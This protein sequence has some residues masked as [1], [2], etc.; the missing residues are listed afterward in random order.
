[1]HTSGKAAAADLAPA[2]TAAL[3]ACRTALTDHEAGFSTD[4]ELRANLVERG[5]VRHG[6]EVYLLDLDEGVWHCYDGVTVRGP[7]AHIQRRDVTRWRLM[8]DHVD[9]T[10]ER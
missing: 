6:G 5:M 2:L 10:I 7:G 4:D 1:M 8:L 3:D 9:D